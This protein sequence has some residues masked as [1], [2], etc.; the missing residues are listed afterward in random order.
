MVFLSSSYF[1]YE[2]DGSA[3]LVEP[4]AEDKEEILPERTVE[5]LADG[6]YTEKLGDLIRTY[7]GNGR[8]VK[9]EVGGSSTTYS[10]GD[11]GRLAAVRTEDN[12]SILV[13]EYVDGKASRT[14]EYD[15]KE[16]LK[17]ISTVL[18]DG[19]IEEIRYVDGVPRY[20]FVFDRDGKRVREASGL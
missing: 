10:Y 20:R 3:V 15:A 7:D 19:T 5:D 14:L 12:T 18:A 4:F 17:T 2:E 16:V 11:G 1:V 6:G 13:T 9:E 8:L